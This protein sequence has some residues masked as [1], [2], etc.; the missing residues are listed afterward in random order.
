M[1]MS[2]ASSI[3]GEKQMFT[4][5]RFIVKLSELYASQFT[6]SFTIFRPF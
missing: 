5:P 4:F 1:N 3:S 6:V 2:T